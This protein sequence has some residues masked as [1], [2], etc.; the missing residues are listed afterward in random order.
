MVFENVGFVDEQCG[1]KGPIWNFQRE[2]PRG[3]VIPY[4]R[5]RCQP[6]FFE[7]RTVSKLWALFYNKD[8][9]RTIRVVTRCSASPHPLPPHPPT[10]ATTV[11]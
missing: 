4:E 3:T 7:K 11:I 8:N 9:A 1:G 2:P 5:Y 10:Y 6:S